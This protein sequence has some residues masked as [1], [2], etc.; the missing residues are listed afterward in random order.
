MSGLVT[1]VKD[2]GD[3]IKINKDPANVA[4]AEKLGWKKKGAKSKQAK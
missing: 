2:N 4:Q 3:E 1:W